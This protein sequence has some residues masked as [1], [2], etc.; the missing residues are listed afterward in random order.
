MGS[1]IWFPTPHC[2]TEV[3][4][5]THLLDL[6]GLGAGFYVCMFICGQS[7]P[8]T[9]PPPF[10][11]QP[12]QC[13]WLLTSSPASVAAVAAAAGGA[14]AVLSAADPESPSED[15]LGHHRPRSPRVA[16]EIAA[17]TTGKVPLPGT[18]LGSGGGGGGYPTLPGVCGLVL[19][20]LANRQA[21]PGHK[22][23]AKLPI[24]CCGPDPAFCK[25]ASLLPGQVPDSGL[26]APA[27]ASRAG[28]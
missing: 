20:L 2:H 8:T 5:C 4:K 3:P 21:L 12:P 7:D 16:R 17:K 1:C 24:A 19:L 9:S 11:Q 23:G 25:R 10:S 18:V 6:A 22:Q 28:R 13:P 26:G 15:I 14:S 27:A